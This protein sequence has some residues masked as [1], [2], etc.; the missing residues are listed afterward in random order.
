VISLPVVVFDGVGAVSGTGQL[1]QFLNITLEARRTN[2]SL[3]ATVDSANSA[4]NAA[5]LRA[6]DQRKP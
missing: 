3:A 6:P 5:I 4:S 2:G 1:F